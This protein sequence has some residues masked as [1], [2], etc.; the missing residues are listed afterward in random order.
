MMFSDLL[1]SFNLHS[2]FMIAQNEID[3]QLRG[4]SL[5]TSMLSPGWREPHKNQLFFSPVSSCNLAY[6]IKQDC[7]LFYQDY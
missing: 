1:Y 3:L 2:N 7:I 4:R 5:I 6:M